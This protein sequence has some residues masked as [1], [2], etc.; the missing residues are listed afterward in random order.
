MRVELACT[1]ASRLRGL[2]GKDTCDGVL[3]LVPCNDVHTFTMRNPIDIAFIASDGTVIEAYRNV[4]PMRRVRNR[5]AVAVIERFASLD[6]WPGA[7]DVLE[8]SCPMWNLAAVHRAEQQ[9]GGAVSSGVEDG[10]RS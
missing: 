8:L 1:L 2:A 5:E 3:L 9:S 7:G 6:W 10:R 4:H